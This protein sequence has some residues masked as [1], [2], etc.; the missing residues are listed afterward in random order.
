MAAG[1]KA[2]KFIGYYKRLDDNEISN[3]IISNFR[4]FFFYP[5]LPNFETIASQTINFLYKM[6]SAPD[7]LCQEIIHDICKKLNEI[8]QKRKDQ[9]METDD[10]ESSQATGLHIPKYLLSRIIFIFG[11]IATKELIYLQDDVHQ[12][13][14]YREELRRQKKN[15]NQTVNLDGTMDR[16]LKR[17]ASANT[18]VTDPND[19]DS[20]YMGATAED[21]LGDY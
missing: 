4:R 3:S 15:G 19:A 2:N 11:Y 6:C 9:A 14:K 18:S 17:L 13:I 20:T 12:N 21:H 8:S 16:S 7:L 1:D 10:Q 5:K